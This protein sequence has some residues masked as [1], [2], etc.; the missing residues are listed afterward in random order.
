MLIPFLGYI[1]IILHKTVEIKIFLHFLLVDKG[2]R[3]GAVRPKNIRILR[4][5]NGSYES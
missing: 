5:L 1:Y 3:S 2:T 4:I